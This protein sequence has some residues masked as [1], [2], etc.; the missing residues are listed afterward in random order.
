MKS[1]D[2]R[3]LG[4]M[5]TTVA[6]Y[7]KSIKMPQCANPIDD[8]V[9][10]KLTEIEGKLTDDTFD[11]FRLKKPLLLLWKKLIEKSIVCLRYFDTREPFRKPDVKKVPYAYGVQ[12]LYEYFEK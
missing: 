2:K 12:N 11:I 4:Q 5:L 1:D 8:E 3:Y 9:F 10:E 6:S 7:R